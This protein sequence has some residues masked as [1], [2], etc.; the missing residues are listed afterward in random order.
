VKARVI[1]FHGWDDPM[2]SPDDVIALG[3]EMTDAGADWQLHAHGG[4][5]HAFMAH[6]ANDPDFGTVY[7]EK[8]A[9]RCWKTFHNFLDECFA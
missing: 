2:V 9:N 5:M 6:G 3:K 7:S 8:T 4:A 1:A